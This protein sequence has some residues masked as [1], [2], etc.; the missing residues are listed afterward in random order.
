MRR[1]DVLR[2]LLYGGLLG[3]ALL[4]IALAAPNH[5]HL[6]AAATLG[7]DPAGHQALEGLALVSSPHAEVDRTTTCPA[8]A[9]VRRFDITALAVDI[10]VNRYGDH[11]PQGR[12]YSL[13]SQVG[14]VRAEE[15][16]S[17]AARAGKGAPAVTKGL[18]GDAIQPLTLR[19]RPGECLRVNLRDEIQGEPA[20][21]HLHGVPWR[22]VSTGRA[23]TENE[24]SAVAQPGGTV[25]YEWAVPA[26]EPSATHYAH[27][28][29]GDQTTARKQTEHGLYAGL[30]VEPS[31]STWTDP[32]SPSTTPGWD[33][34][35]HR[36]DGS[37]FREFTLFYAEDGDEPY[38]PLARNGAFVPLVDDLTGAYKPAARWVNYRSEPFLDR[39]ALEQQ[40]TG[41]YDES[42]AYS[43]YAFGDPATPVM[44]SYVGD[45]VV[46]R[47]LHAGSEVLHV[48]HVHG[49]SIRWRRQPGL[50][51]VDTTSGLTKKPDLL[52]GPSERTDA[53]SMAPA[54][55]FDQWSECGSGGCQASVG[56]FLWH[57]HVAQHYFAGM[58]GLWR[59]YGTLQNGPASTDAL[60]PLTALP[61]RDK[62]TRPAVRASALLGTTVRLGGRPT[63]ITPPVLS[64]WLERVLPPPGKPRGYSA[65]VWDWVRHGQDVLGEPDDRSVWPGYASRTPGVRPQ[66]LFDPVNGMPAYPFLRPHLGKRPPFAPGHGPAPYLDPPRGA[67]LPAP[68]ADGPA[69]VCPI[70]TTPMRLP[71]TALLTPVQ[72]A[73]GITDPHGELY[74]RN[75]ELASYRANVRQRVPLVVRA[76]AQ[77]DCIDVTLVSALTDDAETH[78]LSKADLHI[79]FVQF[80]VQGSDGVV[81]GFNAEQSVRPWRT[82]SVALAAPVA[83]GARV[84]QLQGVPLCQA[85]ESLALGPERPGGA[86]VVRV[87]S[88]R[89][90]TV[91][92]QTPVLSSHPTGEPTTAEFVRYR[93]YPDAQT[94]TA[95][96]HDHVDAISSWRH[97]LFGA[98]VVEPPDAVWTNPT[99]GA[100]IDSGALADVSTR[101]AVG[102]DE[103][104]SFRELVALLQDDVRV[105]QTAH[106]QGGALGER[107][108]PALGKPGAPAAVVRAYVGDPVVLRT[109]VPGTND[110]HTLFVEGHHFRTEAWS[111]TSPPVNALHV[112]ISERYDVV[113]PAAGG[114]GRRAG[115]YVFG[116]GRTSK[117]REGVWGVLQVLPRAAP[118]L[119]PLAGRVPQVAASGPVC[120]RGAPLVRAD[121]T[122][123]ELTIAEQEKGAAFV[124][125]G[126][127]GELSAHPER[128]EP[129]VLH[130]DVGDCLRLVLH[131]AMPSDPLQPQVSLLV[132]DPIAKPLAPGQ[133]GSYDFWAAPALGEATGQLRD[134]AEPLDGPSRGLYGAVVVAARGSRF[135]NPQGHGLPAGAPGTAV[136]VHPPE[137]P[138]Y[139][140]FT[141]FPQ[142]SD[143]DL[144]THAMPYRHEVLGM[145]AMSYRQGQQVL[146]AYPGDPMRMHVVAAVSEQVQGFALDGHRWPLEPGAHGTNVV[147]AQ[148][149]GGRETFTIEPLGGA[150]GEARLSGDFVFGDTRGPYRDAGEF[151]VLR[152]LPSH[153]AGLAPLSSSSRPAWALA[154]AGL[155][156]VLV[157]VSTGMAATRRRRRWVS[158]APAG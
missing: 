33:A 21:F 82:A 53:Q 126:R 26:D 55:T 51:P 144:G 3:V 91:T 85:G 139:R 74:V 136:V 94:G 34:V 6:L 16:V 43:S 135:R 37:S 155:L 140:D 15:A 148:A 18:Q 122:A 50:G 56:D 41:R 117:L 65:G 147:A 137:R 151:G 70:G 96:F 93:W 72:L 49:G 8:G 104:G 79:H 133:R 100:P 158:D 119:R 138:A 110:V 30:I 22:V 102:V 52:P 153:V 24:P 69:S 2:R 77:R 48:H 88:V 83:P 123:T 39:L 40:K 76:R 132:G 107:A 103:S 141:V 17:A 31:G 75:E 27:S 29:G 4:C 90:R 32:R 73:P 101:G 154:L 127:L 23:A 81:A 60:P 20:S 89:G 62:T 124:P 116:D 19:V 64:S 145:Q 115:D 113:I 1:A 130:V 63:L 143:G 71:V 86:E 59:V 131:N 95:Y 45:P 46:Q 150:G 121:V 66:V 112:G 92:L 67:G 114:D 78:G 128:L 125:T 157:M 42:G 54:E 28:H 9:P 47:V 12:M 97:G 156:G 25:S 61:D 5:P 109:L 134:V 152:V 142:D 36:A 120:P 118:G 111:P 10:T 57:C 98:L 44:R 149:V 38:Q 84:L 14:S 68:G 146:E 7:Q 87:T 105:N 129:L 58:W 35:V 108:S 11:D 99:T 106:S 80:D 13:G